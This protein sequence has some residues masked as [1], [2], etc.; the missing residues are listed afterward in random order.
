MTDEQAEEKA[1]WL[2]NAASNG[3]C[4]CW[5]TNT[6]KR[7]QDLFELLQKLAPPEV[8]LSLLH[9][10]FPLDERQCLEQELK[11]KYGR[12]GL[13]PQRAIVVGT[14]V[15][16]QSLDLDFDLLVSDLA[17]IDLLLQRAGRLHRHDRLRPPTHHKPCLWINAPSRD[18]ELSLSGAD[19]AIYTE[20]ILHQTW[21][22]LVHHGQTAK[23]ISLPA[24]YRPLIEA[25]YAAPEPLP[26]HPLRKAWDKLRAKSNTAREEAAMR[27]MPEPDP[28]TPFSYAAT[29]ITFEE[30]EN[31]AAWIV[32]QT[33]LGEETLNIIPLEVQDDVG[34]L[35]D[36][37]VVDLKRE[38][39]REIQ[40]R[41]LRRNLRIS[42]YDAIGVLKAYNVNPKPLF[43]DSALLKDYYLLPLCDN[44]LQ[45]DTAKHKINFTLHPR[46][47][48]M[49]RK[50]K[51]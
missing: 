26:E 22:V 46:L 11:D 25:V 5:M 36:G 12:K 50:E 43:K 45:L 32:A 41:L 21:T 35:P 3:G 39:P 31:S 44:K 19:I 47:G 28:K 14:Q 37:T 27:L 49:I 29:E 4:I 16:E 40:L 8:E 10:Q 34:Q 13:R 38:A 1:R 24:D 42:N 9:S 2:L 7:A 6:V 33:R 15:L 23:G 20:Y 30:N 17:P 51:K 48:L 18:G